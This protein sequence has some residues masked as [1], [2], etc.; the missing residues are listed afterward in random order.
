MVYKVSCRDCSF[1]Y[2]GESKRSWNSRGAE[3]DPGRAGNSESAIEQQVESSDH[4]IHPKDV[5]VIERGA[6]NYH[7]PLFM[8]SWHSTLDLQRH[9]KRDETPS[10]RLHTVNLKLIKGS[11]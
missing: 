11:F 4:K 9:C 3:H 1:I 2:V 6:I 5:H 10:S 7:K 8:E